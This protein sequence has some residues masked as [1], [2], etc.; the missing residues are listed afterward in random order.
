MRLLL[1]VI[2]NGPNQY[3]CTCGYAREHLNDGHILA[4]VCRTANSQRTICHDKAAETL[5][6]FL[7]KVQPDGHWTLETKV[8]QG[9][10]A[11]IVGTIDHQVY[12]I[13]VAIT[14]PCTNH[15]LAQR[16]DVYP[17][18][19]AR[20]REKQKLEHYESARQAMRT[21][22]VTVV[23]FVLKSTGVLG[24]HAAEFIDSS[25]SLPRLLPIANDALAKYRR[26][27]KK[28]LN[29]WVTRG[30]AEGI[31]AARKAAINPTQLQTL[32]TYLTSYGQMREANPLNLTLLATRSAWSNQ[33]SMS[34]ARICNIVGYISQL[35]RYQV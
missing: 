13:D 24:K 4:T 16:S 23:P 17:L 21:S 6:D 31:Q 26:N 32:L 29:V 22:P 9:A 1:P 3:L 14:A 15:A 34:I 35:G 30:L 28:L 8:G 7:T 27:F 12:W 18:T 11:D 19:A 20:I 5:Y 25:C 2:E 10:R 33:A